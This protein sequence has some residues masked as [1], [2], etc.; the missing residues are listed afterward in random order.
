M[1]ITTVAIRASGDVSTISG[2]NSIPT[3]TKNNTAKASRSGSVSRIACDDRVDEDMTIPAK[4]AP[5]AKDTPKKC[6]AP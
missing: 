6:V 4:N 5:S 1:M 3:D 2:L